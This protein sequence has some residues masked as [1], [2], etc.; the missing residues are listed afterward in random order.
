MDQFPVCKGRVDAAAIFRSTCLVNTWVVEAHR[1]SAVVVAAAVE[2][3]RRDHN[4]AVVARN[5]DRRLLVHLCRGLAFAICYVISEEIH[6][7]HRHSNREE[8]RPRV[9]FHAV[10]DNREAEAREAPLASDVAVEDHRI[11]V[12]NNHYFQ[13]AYVEVDNG[14]I[15]AVVEWAVTG[16]LPRLLAL[17]EEDHHCHFLR[18]VSGACWFALPARVTLQS[19]FRFTD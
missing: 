5:T 18:P 19:P 11:V 6:D 17:P 8:V 7:T 1:G 2:A 4:P 15:A 3:H 13:E 16:L 12:D 10:V 14:D 9:T